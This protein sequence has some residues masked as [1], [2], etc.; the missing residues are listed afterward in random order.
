MRTSLK[1]NDKRIVVQFTYQG[2]NPSWHLN[3]CGD[4][5]ENN[6][7]GPWGCEPRVLQVADD[8][9]VDISFVLANGDAVKGRSRECSDTVSVSVLRV[10]MAQCFIATNLR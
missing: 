1:R 7:N 8:G 2:K 4:I 6:M 5:A 3:A 9:K 10:E